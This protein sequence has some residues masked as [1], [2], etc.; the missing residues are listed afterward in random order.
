MQIEEQVAIL[1][2]EVARLKHQ[3]RNN[4]SDVTPWWQK[5]SGTFA[6]NPA[7]DE[8]MKLGREYRESLRI[9]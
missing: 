9:K 6:D 4:S 3:V 8:A 1:E 2:A 5:V 7:F